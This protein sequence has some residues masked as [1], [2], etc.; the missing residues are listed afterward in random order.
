MEKT[1]K[2]PRKSFTNREYLFYR[3][4]LRERIIGSGFNVH[5]TVKNVEK[6]KQVLTTL[7]KMKLIQK[8]LEFS[9]LDLTND[10]G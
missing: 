10:K 3:S 5:G 8:N 2:P 7:K 1:Q 6:K 4:L 9:I